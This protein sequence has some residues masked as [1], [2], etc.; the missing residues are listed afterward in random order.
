M[1]PRQP[2]HLCGHEYT[3]ASHENDEHASRLLHENPVQDN[4]ASKA[5]GS[6]ALV[7]MCTLCGVTCK[8]RLSLQQHLRGKKHKKAFLL[9]TYNPDA[10]E[11][12]YNPDATEWVPPPRE[13]C[14]DTGD[15]GELKPC[16]LATDAVGG[17]EKDDHGHVSEERAQARRAA[18]DFGVDLGQVGAAVVDSLLTDRANRC[19]FPSTLRRMIA[20]RL[21]ADEDL[22]KHDLAVSALL[23]TKLAQSQ[24]VD[25]APRLSPSASE[26]VGDILQTSYFFL[27][28][29][30]FFGVNKL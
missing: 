11:L 30:L 27:Q 13:E 10:A 19:R 29:S 16:T 25:T 20:E 24:K 14:L 28:T 17:E 7:F 22:L 5:C 23:D 15:G 21:G 3:Q 12:V 4:C 1:V 26:W 18:T 2:L 9:S 6:W 8:T